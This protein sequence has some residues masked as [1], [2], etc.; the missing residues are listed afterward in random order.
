MSV[1]KR[2]NCHYHFV[3][4]PL[5]L[6]HN[7]NDVFTAASLLLVLSLSLSLSL[8]LPLYSPSSGIP[9]QLERLSKK[10]VS[11]STECVCVCANGSAHILCSV[12]MC[13]CDGAH[14]LTY[15]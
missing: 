3:L 4:P 7:E 9:A 10:P 13:V 15:V 5:S 6:V 8:Y 14:A 11:A 1:T 2:L 12:C